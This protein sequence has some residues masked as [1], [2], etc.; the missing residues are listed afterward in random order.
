MNPTDETDRKIIIEFC[1][2]LEKSKVLFNGLRELPQ[3][4]YKQWQSY[5]GRTFDVYT[6][7][8]KFQ[9]QHRYLL[10]R[11]YGLKRWQIGEI[12]SKIGQLYYHFYLRTSETAYLREAFS[13]YQAI[14][15]RRYYTHAL[16]EDRCELVVK[17][18]RY[19][20]RFIVVALLMNRLKVVDDLVR[21]LD[22]HIVEY[23]SIYNADD[24]IEWNVVVD[25]V[26]G[27]LDV[28]PAVQIIYSEL[29][30]IDLK[31]RI[32][33]YETPYI[34]RNGYM[35]L[36][37]QDVII[38]G[39][40]NAQVKFSELTIDMYRIVHTVEREMI[41]PTPPMLNDEVPPPGQVPPPHS[42]PRGYA[43][44]DSF[45]RDNPHKY[46]LF[47]PSA[48]QLLVYLA[49]S[50]NDLPPNGAIML[51]IS[52][53]GSTA[54][55]AKSTDSNS[56][57]GGFITSGKQETTRDSS[58]DSRESRASQ[59]QTISRGKDHALLYPGDLNPFTRRPLFI[60]IES[61]CSHLMQ[62]ISHHFNQPLVILLSAQELPSCLNDRNYQ[63]NLLTL[64]LHN[65]LMG[66]CAS[67]ELYSIEEAV[68]NTCYGFVLDFLFQCAQLI[69]RVRIDTNFFA[70][71]GDDFLKIII[72]R[73]I[74]CECSLRLNRNFRSRNH[75]VRSVPSLP[76]EL[77]S[78]ATL[79]AIVLRIAD[80]L[81][82]KSQF[83]D[84]P[85][86]APGPAPRDQN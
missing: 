46:L 1:H 83:L 82:V 50:C 76:D 85:V 59:P 73:F 81:G 51:Y 44:G 47:K 71:L 22:N 27:F 72:L 41:R 75:L 84:V 33:P 65:P 15:G 10:D 53:D 60:I 86:Q 52:A 79:V 56:S 42:T 5:F 4:G 28:E 11:K 13:F 61:N 17:K 35:H 43:A 37:L 32:N 9:Q 38:V 57:E 21:E 55:S 80:H 23:G 45:R 18:L 40:S 67:C 8:W 68:Y 70:F 58:R 62:N 26:K 7:L 78:H 30:A 25:E 31:N 20:A 14:R 63:G 6:K 24:Q 36:S 64:F 19:Y 69:L 29:P 39:S 12:A 2:L 16:I 34:E 54:N 48:Q 77:L 74:F 3:Y 49:S 66:F